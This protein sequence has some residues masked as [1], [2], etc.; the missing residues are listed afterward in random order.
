MKKTTMKFESKNAAKLHEGRKASYELIEKYHEKFIDPK[1]GL[2]EDKYL[3]NRNC[4]V[5]DSNNFSKLFQC[6]GGI[7]VK[8]NGCTMIYTDP[9]FTQDALNKYYF[10][11]DTGQAAITDNESD[12]YREIYSKGLQSITKFITKGRM[13]DIGCSSG[14]FLDYAKDLGW[15]TCGIELGQAEGQI[16]RSKGH[17]IYNSELETIDFDEKFDVITLWDVFEHI[18]NGKQYLSL[19]YEL[20]SDE[21][22]LFLQIPSSDSLAAKILREKCNAFDGLEHCNMYNPKTL[23]S[24]LE[25]CNYEI[26]QLNS[27]ISEIA[28]MNNYFSYED[29]YF[30]QTIYGENL[31]DCIDANFIHENLLGYKLQCVVK[32]S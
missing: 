21:G 14:V 10:S 5:C 22:V 29:S 11:L 9:V 20:L 19:I 32:K 3:E 28:V 16:A 25:A 27:V 17:I 26:L 12:F 13:L 31:L 23:K 24:V 7:Y 15:S 4:P 18:P 30:G 8:C 2:F 6:F 1:T